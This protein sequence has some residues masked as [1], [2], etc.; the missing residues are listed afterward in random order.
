MQGSCFFIDLHLHRCRQSL[1]S[2]GNNGCTTGNAG[3]IAALVH[4]GHRCIR[5]GIGHIFPG[6]V[7]RCKHK[8]CNMI[9]S[10]S[11]FH[12]VISKGDALQRHLIAYRDGHAVADGLVLRP[13]PHIGSTHTHR[14]HQT[15][16]I[17]GDH[18]LI[19]A[20]IHKIV[21]WQLLRGAL[22]GQLAGGI[23]IHAHGIRRKSDF[24]RQNMTWEFEKNSRSMSVR[25]YNNLIAYSIKSRLILSR[26]KSR[27]FRYEE[28]TNLCTITP[29]EAS[30]L[31]SHTGS[32]AELIRKRAAFF[33]PR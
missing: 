1:A 20:L 32:K 11:H 29:Q 25:S 16:I 14:G 26:Q 4:L 21:Q 5:R 22:R 30:P 28:I 10:D 17:D 2:G 12:T 27:V 33:H 9:F 6:A 13:N 31:L 7:C 8:S 15:G 3:D 19:G 24:L 18:S 23:H